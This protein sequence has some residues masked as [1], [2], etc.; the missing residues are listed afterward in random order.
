MPY[1]KTSELPDAVQKLPS[2]AQEIYMAAFNSSF[3]K[4][5]DEKK[6]H[7]IAWS[8]VEVKY[9]KDDDGNWTSKESNPVTYGDLVKEATSRKGGLKLL[10]SVK[11]DGDSAFLS[12]KL[13][14]LKSLPVVR[15][16]E[17]HE[18]EAAVYSY[19]PDLNKPSTWQLRLVEDGSTRISKAQLSKAAAS[20]SPG[21][22][23]GSKAE[24]PSEDL[25]SVKR[26]I[27]LEYTKL[28]IAESEIPR[29][30]KET[31]VRT[32][33]AEFMPLT[34]ASITTK[35]K[36]QVV[37]IKPGFN[38]SKTR[39]YPKEMLGRDHKIFENAKMYA[40][41]PS[42]S[43]ERERPERSI[44]DWVAVLSNVRVREQDGSIIGDYTVVE[45]WMEAK[46]AKLRDNG[47]LDKIGVSINAV[48][49]ASRQKVEGVETNFIEK[50]VA[51]RSVDFVTEPGA[52]GAVEIFE[53]NNP[54]LDVDL[55][56]VES[57]KE[58]RPDIVKAIEDVVKSEFAKE[59]K[60]KMTLEEE[61]KQ[62]KESNQTLTTENTSLKNQIAEADKV[63]AK[64]TAQA[65]I[66]EAVDKAELPDATKAR[67]MK[68]FSEAVVTDG[69]TEA[70]TEETEYIS[71]LA[72]S[73]KVKGLGN[74][75]PQKKTPEESHEE[76][77]E[78]FKRTG[79]SEAEAE[80]AAKG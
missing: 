70:I 51:A 77:V 19:T 46:L 40:D 67:L 75:T 58:R 72:E 33:V 71:T 52:G 79:M 11:T 43:E 29:W 24:I 8:A 54:K 64:A 13:T 47:Q 4:D 66:K 57:F 50:L 3:E 2:H 28:N 23:R 34:E 63:K 60:A 69:I 12:S 42:E 17:G 35:G 20:L 25:P 74:T 18:Y 36:G 59:A 38:T 56:D 39:Y 32:L 26:R 7:A 5:N 45:P 53:S 49:S 73:G 41:H 22:F 62:L 14:E 78:S 48:G 80:I 76:L 68:R 6:A 61:N 55:V 27:R 65:A 30:V 16:E 21:G 10:E 1:N 9:K 15:V 44:K 37:V 31:E